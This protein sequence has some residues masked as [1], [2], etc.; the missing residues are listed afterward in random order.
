MGV[1]GVP[2]LYLMRHGQTAW[3]AEGRMQGR[4][5][6]P[7]TDLGRQQA[8]AQA[9]LLTG[10]DGDLLRISS[11]QGRAVASARIVFGGRPFA[12]DPRLAEIDIGAFSGQLIA[13]LRRR[14]PA[15]FLGDRL[16]WYDR[17]PG[18]EHFAGLRARVAAFLDDLPGPAI[19]VTHGIT[20]RML[21]LV[22][23]G[24]PISALGD[25]PVQQGAVHVLRAGRHETW[26]PEGVA[27][28]GLEG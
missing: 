2:D 24:G 16:A 11:P 1:T 5:D 8:R 23:T 13:D 9:G 17:A 22:A 7:L 27:P 28:A 14:H 19:I 15:I 21:R 20:L 25:L 4:L 12:T 18:G 26:L 10:L 6:S 3:N